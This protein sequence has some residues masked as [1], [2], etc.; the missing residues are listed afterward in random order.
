MNYGS[1]LSLFLLLFPTIIPVEAPQQPG[2]EAYL[3]TPL[4]KE[5]WVYGYTTLLLSCKREAKRAK[6][7]RVELQVTLFPC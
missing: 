3:S 6:S 1:S 7:D 4:Q 5:V 2:R